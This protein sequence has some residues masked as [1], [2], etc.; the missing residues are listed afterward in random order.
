MNIAMKAGLAV[1][2]L[3]ATVLLSACNPS[4]SASGS[5]SQPPA[6]P[7]GAASSA[8]AAASPATASTAPPGSATAGAAP[9]EHSACE[10][11]Q[12]KVSDGAGGGT[13]VDA[14]GRAEATFVLVNSGSDPCDMAGFPGVDLIGTDKATGK[15]M[16][17]SLPRTGVPGS[18][19]TVSGNNT[20]G[21]GILYA[22]SVKSSTEFDATEMIMTPP[23]TFTPMTHKFASPLKIELL[24]GNPNA[25]V[26]PVG[27]GGHP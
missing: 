20:A 12:L 16:R 15:Q 11:T 18:K 9:G 1:G 7:S 21:F 2:S 14:D 26:G 25:G 4:T 10:A 24:N 17:F 8:P 22:A 3:S 19:V 13:G 27:S 6:A 23:D 5:S